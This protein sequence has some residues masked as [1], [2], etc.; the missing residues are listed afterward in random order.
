M[1]PLIKK[2]TTLELD[3]LRY[4]SDGNGH[5]QV[6]S[7]V[8]LQ[9]ESPREVIKQIAKDNLLG[10]LM[11]L[12]Q[13]QSIS[14]RLKVMNHFPDDEHW[15]AQFCCAWLEKTTDSGEKSLIIQAALNWPWQPRWQAQLDVINAQLDALIADV[16]M[17]D[18]LAVELD[19]S[20]YQSWKAQLNQVIEW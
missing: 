9:G 8:W 18:E 19:L 7:V 5:V 16:D 4:H 3:S 6:E 20:M 12:F 10:E 17:D 11:E 2:L 1:N 14:W 13:Q 15:A